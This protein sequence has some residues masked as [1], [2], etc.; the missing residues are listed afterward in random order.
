[1]LTYFFWSERRIRWPLAIDCSLQC[2]QRSGGRK[3]FVLFQTICFFERT[4]IAQ[5]RVDAFGTWYGCCGAITRWKIR[6]LLWKIK[7]LFYM[8][9]LFEEIKT[10]RIGISMG[11][12]WCETAMDVWFVDCAVVRLFNHSYFI[13][14]WFMLSDCLRMVSVFAQLHDSPTGNSK[15]FLGS[16]YLLRW[17][18]SKNP[19]GSA[20]FITAFIL[21]DLDTGLHCL[22]NLKNERLKKR[23]QRNHIFQCC[24]S[25]RFAFT[26]STH[27]GLSVTWEHG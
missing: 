14:T 15:L 12:E 17:A 21:S 1:M 13:P 3:T 5:T 24:A 4:I 6:Q 11:G 22:I 25:H 26:A 19:L 10:V 23:Y 8:T 7:I 27:L 20:S 9:V 18:S 16:S 2:V